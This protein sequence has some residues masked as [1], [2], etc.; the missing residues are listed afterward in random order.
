MLFA[1]SIEKGQNAEEESN[2]LRDFD[3]RLAGR[4]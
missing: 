3:G 2:F 4:G 1:R